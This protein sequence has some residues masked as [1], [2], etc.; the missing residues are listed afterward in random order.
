[1]KVNWSSYIF[2]FTAMGVIASNVI[3]EL[4]NLGIDV[5]CN[6]LNPEHLKLDDYPIEVQKAI[7]PKLLKGLINTFNNSAGMSL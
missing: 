4:D 5:S 3:R 7:F 1:M 2:P 6:M